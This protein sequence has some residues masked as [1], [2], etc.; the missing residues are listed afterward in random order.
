VTTEFFFFKNK[1]KEFI[2][3]KALEAS[4]SYIYL[5]LEFGMQDKLKSTTFTHTAED[6][7]LLRISIKFS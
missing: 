5:P 7:F 3:P 1:Q 6:K 2:Q 4:T